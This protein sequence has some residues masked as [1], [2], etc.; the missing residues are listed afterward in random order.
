M[1]DEITAE[2]ESFVGQIVPS[3][4]ESDRALATVLAVALP[5]DG[6]SDGAFEAIVERWR[7][8]SMRTSG[9]ATFDGAARAIGC[10]QAVISDFS[11]R[12]HGTGPA[13]LAAPLNIG[14]GTK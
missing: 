6:R 4:F 14:V 9:L 8:H 13:V 5:P 3:F 2:I 10:A 7:G 12:G 1:I 11:S